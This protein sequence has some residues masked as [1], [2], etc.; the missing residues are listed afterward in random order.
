MKK[1]SKECQG[2]AKIVEYYTWKLESNAV[3]QKRNDSIKS[4][5]RWK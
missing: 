2:M 1:D 4:A 3:R 5:Q